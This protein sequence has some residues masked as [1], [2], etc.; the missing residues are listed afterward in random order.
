MED[1][2]EELVD[3]NLIFFD[4]SAHKMMVNIILFSGPDTKNDF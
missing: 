1:D 4:L 2:V 3:Q